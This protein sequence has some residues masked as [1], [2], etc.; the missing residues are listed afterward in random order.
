M[1]RNGIKRTPLPAGHFF[2]RTVYAS[3]SLA[4]RLLPLLP[5][6]CAR[7]KRNVDASTAIHGDKQAQVTLAPFLESSSFPFTFSLFPL[8]FILATV[9]LRDLLPFLPSFFTGG[10]D[11]RRD[12]LLNSDGRT[13]FSTL[14]AGRVRNALGS[15]ARLSGA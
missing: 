13:T 5:G 9:I 12:S 8:P 15:Q 10:V 11:D 4:P 14:A 7:L 2:K 1:A 6:A 3:L